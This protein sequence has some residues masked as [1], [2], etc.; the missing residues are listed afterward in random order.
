MDSIAHHYDTSVFKKL[1]AF[2]GYDFFRPED[3][4]HDNKYLP[5][6]L[7][8]KTFSLFGWQVIIPVFFLSGWHTMKSFM[9][10]CF[11]LAVAFGAPLTYFWWADFFVYRLCFGVAFNVFYNIVWEQK[12]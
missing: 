10:I 5:G 1:D 3:A 8:R 9:L 12:K 2:L 6:T 11:S 4:K 7:I